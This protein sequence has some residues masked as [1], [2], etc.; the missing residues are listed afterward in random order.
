[1]TRHLKFFS[2]GLDTSGADSDGRYT[3][4]W[5]EDEESVSSRHLMVFHT[6][7]LITGGVNMRKRHV[8]NDNVFV[9]YFDRNSALRKLLR[10][11]PLHSMELKSSLLSGD[12]GFVNIFVEHLGET[13]RV[14]VRIRPGL[15]PETARGLS[16]LAGDDIIPQD[17]VAAHVRKLAL[18]ADI[19]CRSLMA[20]LLGAPTNWEARR[21]QLRGMERFSLDMVV[22]SASVSR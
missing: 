11:S 6:V 10:S 15:S 12:F 3:L 18:A 20:D 19:T 16:H 2:A 7:P 1:M 5:I 17:C 9:V 13:C 14:T 8:G 22:G 21:R 4:L